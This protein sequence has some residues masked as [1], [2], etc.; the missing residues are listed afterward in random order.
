MDDII[1]LARNDELCD[2]LY[3]PATKKIIERGWIAYR[4]QEYVTDIYYPP[5]QSMAYGQTTFSG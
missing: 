2:D 5:L 3:R 1:L 4:I